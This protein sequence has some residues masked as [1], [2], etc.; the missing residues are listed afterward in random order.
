MRLAA[1]RVNPLAQTLCALLGLA[2]GLAAAAPGADRTRLSSAPLGGGISL[3]VTLSID[4]A[5]PPSNYDS[6]GAEAIATAKVG[7]TARWCY[8]VINHDS[9][10][11]SRHTLVSDEFGSILS[12]FI[13]VL[14]PGASAFITQTEAVSVS[15]SESA[16][17][18]AFN[19]G[20][21]DVSIDSDSA[22]LTALPPL[23]FALTVSVDPDP[24]PPSYDHCGSQNAV[25]AESGKNVRWCYR[26]R[27]TSA[28]TFGLHSVVSDR[29]GGVLNAFPYVLA[30]DASAFITQVE[31]V[32]VADLFESATWTAFNPG[33]SD[34]YQT[35]AAAAVFLPPV[36]AD[37][38][39]SP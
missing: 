19:P 2:C 33:P 16:T 24:L 3:S 1:P 28:L 12:A 8:R 30:P 39:E 29:L 10:E 6:C 4:P 13:Y 22:S 11:L 21:V 31:A 32:G 17:W 23:D 25:L 26:I 14:P 15:R 36:F 27:N 34:E 20:P 9:I 35:T 5:D 38:F 18:T 7:Q 37:G